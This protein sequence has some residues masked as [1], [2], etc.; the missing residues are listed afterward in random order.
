MMLTL[1]VEGGSR[2]C[3]PRSHSSFT[4]DKAPGDLIPKMQALN[5]LEKKIS[6]QLDFIDHCILSSTNG[7]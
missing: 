6:T 2:G 4:D 1:N 7:I 3:A 5:L